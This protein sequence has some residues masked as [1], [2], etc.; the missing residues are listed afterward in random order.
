LTLRWTATDKN[1][2]HRGVTIACSEKPDGAWTPV[3]MGVEN[4]GQY[5]W[6]MPPTVPRRFYVRVEA[7]DQA[8][9][10]GMALAK[11]PVMLD[12]P[13]PSVSILGVE[14]GEK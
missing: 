5:I 9:N 3:A 13:E 6:P 10:V 1:L 12:P 14:P 4:T 8:G 11:E 7:T 2:S